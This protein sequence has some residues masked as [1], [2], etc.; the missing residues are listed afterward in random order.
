MKITKEMG[1]ACLRG[2]EAL[3]DWDFFDSPPP[4]AYA[5][6]RE[7]MNDDDDPIV[8]FNE[9]QTAF[10]MCAAIAGVKP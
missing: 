8:S 10:A 5:A 6:V 3:A 7:L 4:A 9:A 1:R 2:M